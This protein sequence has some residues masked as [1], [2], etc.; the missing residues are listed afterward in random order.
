MVW[1]KVRDNTD[2]KNKM[3]KLIDE[4]G[5]RFEGVEEIGREDDIKGAQ[6]EGPTINAST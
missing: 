1:A 4:E 2:R 5:K 6:C 3:G